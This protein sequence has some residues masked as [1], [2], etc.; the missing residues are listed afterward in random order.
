MRLDGPAHN[1]G[2]V[3]LLVYR[4][5]L[6]DATELW[7][8]LGPLADIVGGGTPIAKDDG[9]CLKTPHC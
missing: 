7:S 1:S 8:S 5:N 9:G 6:T 2:Q 3:C 4:E